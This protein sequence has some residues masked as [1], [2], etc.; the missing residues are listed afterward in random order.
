MLWLL[1]YKFDPFLFGFKDSCLDFLKP[2][3]RSN[4][5][6]PGSAAGQGT[7]RYFLAPQLLPLPF[8]APTATTP[9]TS[10]VKVAGA[11]AKKIV[12]VAGALAASIAAL[13][14]TNML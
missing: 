2:G 8:P 13:A 4:L 7:L 3:G 14:V 12:M 5:D 1:K 11:H 9:V 10:S 6:H